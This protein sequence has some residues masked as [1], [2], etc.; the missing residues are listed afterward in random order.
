MLEEIWKVRMPSATGSIG[1]R[2]LPS[3]HAVRSLLLPD[4]WKIAWHNTEVIRPDGS[5]LTGD[6]LKQWVESGV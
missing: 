4:A 2:A 3:A 6:A 1:E 5:S